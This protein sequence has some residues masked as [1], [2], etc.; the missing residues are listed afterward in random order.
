M[1]VDIGKYNNLEVIKI[2]D[3]GIYLNGYEWGEIL[4]P[5]QYVPTGTKIGDAIDCFIYY[6]S[7]D[8]IIATTLK[9]IATV[10]EFAVLR[11]I[12][13][14][15]A[16]AFLDWGLPKDLLVPYGE[17]KSRMQVDKFYVVYIYVDSLTKRIVASSKIEKF[18]STEKP[19]Y[20]E[21]QEVSII[22]YQ[23]TDIGYK[24]IINQKNVGVIHFSDVFKNIKI[25]DKLI[26]YIKSIKEDFKINLVLQKPGYK[27]IDNTSQKILDYIKSNNGFV[28]FTDKTPADIIY[29]EFGISKKTFKKSVGFLYKKR[30]IAIEKN[31]LKLT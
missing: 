21:G 23:K 10:G 9:P 14:N 31:G 18:I 17:Q 30:L 4:M 12:S 22:I 20:N 8:R 16:G 19:Q 6:D 15:N 1:S 5:R 24:A 2:L 3:F 27:A 7:E 26:G 25:G 11:A 13:V 29:N 28:P